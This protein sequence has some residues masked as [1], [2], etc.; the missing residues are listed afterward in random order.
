MSVLVGLDGV[1]AGRGAATRAHLGH[2]LAEALA[3]VELFAALVADLGVTDVVLLE[4]VHVPV[5]RRLERLATRA[6]D[7]ASVF[8]ERQRVR[9]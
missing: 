1:L 9:D 7:L 8:L 3:V 5:A 6:A 2:V 4:Q